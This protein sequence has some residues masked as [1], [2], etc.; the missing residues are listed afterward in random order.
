MLRV[1]CLPSDV[2]VIERSSSPDIRR[3]GAYYD[4]P[5]L[6]PVYQIMEWERSVWVYAEHSPNCV[7]EAMDVF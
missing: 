7:P 1:H 6:S 4:L 2:P 5:V 3:K